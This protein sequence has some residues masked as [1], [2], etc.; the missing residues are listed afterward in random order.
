MLI[1]EFKVLMERLAPVSLAE[2]W[3]NAGLQVGEDGDEV[4]KVL[5]SLDVTAEVVAEAESTSC[6]MILSHHPLIF[7]P[8]SSVSGDSLTGRLIRRACT[9]G[10]S[11]FAAHTN[12][13]SARGGL[14][15]II[16]E[17]VGLK[18]VAPLAGAASG[19]SKLAAFVP[20]GD[21]ERVRAALFAAG[22]G[23]IGNYEHCSFTAGG[24]GTFL[25]GAGAH[26]AV[27]ALGSDE[28]VPEQRLEMVFPSGLEDD[29]IAA[30]KEASS[31]EEPAYDIYRLNTRRHSAG[32]GRIG[33][34]ESAMK[35]SD[36]TGMAAALF[37]LDEARFAGARDRSI[38]RVAVVPGGGAGYIGACAAR[39][40]DCLV[41][42][43][44]KYHDGIEARELGLALIDIP[45]EISEG[46]S[47]S[48]WSSRLQAELEKAGGDVKLIF[49]SV[50]RDVWQKSLRLEIGGDALKGA[51]S[52]HML[53]VD[54]GS[55]GNPGPAAIGAVLQDP[56][57]GTVETLSSYIGVATNNIA[58]YQALIAGVEMALDHNVS[59]LVIF[60]DSE[61]IVRQ[62]KGKYR[63]KNERLRPYFQEA[64]SV[65]SRLMQF[66]LRSI[67]RS[68]NELADGLVN[69]ALDES[70]R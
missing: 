39:G 13:D 60:S 36:L 35:L 17:L 27:G 44:F 30:L 23:V 31:Y 52:M 67:P 12:L 42:G 62:I 3:D 15:D 33:E 56:E 46:V 53:F 64:R 55:R 11:V 54:G 1:G 32:A 4:S 40:A 21:L 26:P 41:S 25:P 65:L 70:Q 34:L 6:D 49:S 51:E 38:R 37:G 45:H 48:S 18:K 19:S 61:L 68:S 43:D 10:I 58:E 7:R 47:L 29:V 50:S 5:I 8:I 20:P 2:D 63:V 24:T 57:G 69:R 22:A 16:A 14:A 59:R 66:D 28:S 9:A